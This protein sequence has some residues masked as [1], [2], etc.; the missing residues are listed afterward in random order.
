MLAH[1]GSHH[2]MLP[3]SF[4]RSLEDEFVRQFYCF[5][6]EPGMSSVAWH[7]ATL[8]GFKQYWRCMY[9]AETC[10]VHMMDRPQYRLECGHFMCNRCVE[11]FGTEGDENIDLHHCVLC[12]QDTLGF[13]IRKLPP[14]ATERL[15][16]IDGGGARGVIPLVFLQ[17]LE[18][19]VGLQYPV[20]ENFD[21]IVGTSSGRSMW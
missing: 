14:T 6:S 21:F 17:A 16:S 9:S 11:R 10:F 18:E 15:L 20:Q 2:M 8:I 5:T 19:A 3:S 13:K 12:D 4:I 7:R 1:E